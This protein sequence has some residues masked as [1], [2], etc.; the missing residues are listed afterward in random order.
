M[1][2]DQYGPICIRDYA[3]NRIEVTLGEP[4]IFEIRNTKSWA[5]LEAFNWTIVWGDQ[6]GVWET[7][8]NYPR[9][10]YLA[11]LES[12]RLS[13]TY[14]AV[15]VYRATFYFQNGGYHVG[16]AQG[17]IRQA[18]G[19]PGTCQAESHKFDVVVKPPKP[20]VADAGAPRYIVVTRSRTLASD[21]VLD[22]SGSWSPSGT[23]M[24]YQWTQLDGPVQCRRLDSR[25]AGLARQ[26]VVTLAKQGES[27][28]DICLGAHKFQL[29]ASDQWGTAKSSVTHFLVLDNT[30]P[31]PHAGDPQ[32]LF[33]GSGYRLREDL[34]LRADRSFDPDG[35][36]IEYRW[37][38]ISA[39]CPSGAAWSSG[40]VT[41]PNLTRWAAGTQI[42]ASCVGTYRYRV[43]VRDQY[44]YSDIAEVQHTI[45]AIPPTLT[46][47]APVNAILVDDLNNRGISLDV[48][49]AAGPDSIAPD[50][51][52]VIVENRR[53]VVV[54][55]LTM[56]S[57]TTSSST[58]WYGQ[59]PSGEQ[60]PPGDYY[61]RASA[62]TEGISLAESAVVRITVVS[63]EVS[64][65][66]GTL[67]PGEDSRQ[68]R[69]FLPQILPDWLLNRL[70]GVRPPPSG[71][72]GREILRGPI[73]RALP[74][75][76]RLFNAAPPPLQG[77]VQYVRRTEPRHLGMPRSRAAPLML[78]IQPTTRMNTVGP[79]M[80]SF[81]GEIVAEGIDSSEVNLLE[82]RIRLRARDPNNPVNEVVHYPSSDWYELPAGTWRALSST[83]S[84]CPWDMF[85][86]QFF[87]GY[88]SAE[89]ELTHR[90][91][92]L[93]LTSSEDVIIGGVNPKKSQVH[94]AIQEQSAI[95]AAY[96]LTRLAHF[97]TDETQSSPG[98]QGKVISRLPNRF[99]IGQVLK[100]NTSGIMWNWRQNAVELQRQ[101]A[102]CK[103][104]ASEYVG[105]VKQGL[106]WNVA[107]GGR[108]PNER[109]AFPWS[110]P[111]SADQYNL[112]VWS[113]YISNVR[114]HDWDESRHSWIRRK[115]TREDTGAGLRFADECLE[116]AFWL[117]KG[118][119]PADWDDCDAGRE[120]IL[121]L[122]MIME[123]KGWAEGAA[124]MRKWLSMPGFASSA[125][126]P[127]RAGN[128]DT[129]TI[130]M[131]FVL[132]YPWPRRIYQTIFDEQL[133]ATEKAQM[134]IVTLLR[135][136][137]RGRLRTSTFDFAWPV[138]ELDPGP[139]PIENYDICVFPI[140]RLL[141]DPIDGLTASLGDC[142]FKVN[143]AGR[144]EAPMNTRGRTRIVVTH[145]GVHVQDL[146]DFNG[147]QP[148]GC[149]NECTNEVS[150]VECDG[151][152]W[153]FNSTFDDFRRRTGRG[154]DMW[155]LSDVKTTRLAKEFSFYAD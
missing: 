56:S 93:A 155:I 36:R 51:L 87:G 129:T 55:R 144:I 107:T 72:R 110:L 53:R 122:P 100:P 134:Q 149:W 25:D 135:R 95:V 41:M 90:Q 127:P 85:P 48:A 98:S 77:L 78:M 112:E 3:P 143:L 118:E 152:V 94:Q 57:D 68:W 75:V 145:V 40:T 46:L 153:Y 63:I 23:S 4:A 62:K 74:S 80:P 86:A 138:D 2:I 92:V 28:S 97:T 84:S 91:T 44:R 105:Q 42:S 128:I 22:G 103:Q 59:L 126:H 102:V 9:Q 17:P 141:S 71:P 45:R 120:H 5:V 29:E 121:Q 30:V 147:F 130:T 10:R 113:R 33:L 106:L 47:V 125:L 11:Y 79:Q 104:N 31:V 60:L 82:T 58:L 81:A 140:R 15:G 116:T 52:Y 148:L 19:Q 24:S 21:F 38:E 49:I 111:L 1:A 61:F 54:D 20:P 37:D 26:K 43:T 136:L 67:P 115:D 123:R 137:N 132:S 6:P 99:G 131:D 16:N 124:L 114:Y 89:I 96:Q 109:V 27:A 69:D 101:L 133:Y 150:R 70:P 154:G 151:G 66:G 83:Q 142:A 14:Q 88:V 13:H 12:Q 35:D 119:M 32:T 139:E 108:P 7:E 34:V 76:R 117:A 39:P 8:G 146:Y 64:L 73:P 65:G 18:D 50:E